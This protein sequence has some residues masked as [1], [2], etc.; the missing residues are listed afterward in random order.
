VT[1]SPERRWPTAAWQS[2]ITGSRDEALSAIAQILFW[3]ALI[4]VPVGLV[5][6]A[7]RHRAHGELPDAGASS[8]VASDNVAS[9]TLRTR[10]A[11]PDGRE[12]ANAMVDINSGLAEAIKGVVEDV[13]G[14]AKVV[15]GALTGRDDLFNEGKSSAGQG[16]SSA[17]RCKERGRSRVG[18]YSGQGRR[19]A[20]EGRATVSSNRTA[21]A[22]SPLAAG[23]FA[24]SNTEQPVLQS[25]RHATDR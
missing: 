8:G 6:Q 19:E 11:P 25:F 12:D 17:Q 9:D 5:L 15:V 16:P 21:K 1:A 13:K 14:E 2:R 24:A 3:M 4:G 20:P 18:P 23:P 7:R 22:R 10:F